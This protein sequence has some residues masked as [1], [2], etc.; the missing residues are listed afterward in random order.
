MV[1]WKR[2]RNVFKGSLSSDHLCSGTN[3]V[4]DLFIA[5]T[6]TDIAMLLE[7]ITRFFP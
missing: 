4:D 2:I 6:T 5:G 1:F 3:C 7:P